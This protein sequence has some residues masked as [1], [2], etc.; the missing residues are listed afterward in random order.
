MNVPAHKRGSPAVARFTID[1]MTHSTNRATA[2]ALRPLLRTTETNYGD[3]W[4]R[5]VTHMHEHLAQVI[6]YSRANEI[7][8]P[9]S[10]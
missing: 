4:V 8:P 7:V 9:W 2:S 5:L 6:A 10:R 3:L 1:L